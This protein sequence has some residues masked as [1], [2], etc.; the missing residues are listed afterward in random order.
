MGEMVRRGTVSNHHCNTH[1][2]V[3]ITSEPNLGN[4]NLNCKEQLDILQPRYVAN[5]T[6]KLSLILVCS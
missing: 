4:A 6:R 3:W 2:T 5:K 1:L